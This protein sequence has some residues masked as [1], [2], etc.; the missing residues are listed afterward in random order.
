MRK[1]LAAIAE[2]INGEVVGDKNIIVTGLSGIQEAKEGDITFL[3][4][5][6]YIPLLNKTEASAVITARDVKSSKKAII[7]T[8]NPSLA[9]ANL[10]TTITGKDSHPFNG[11]HASAL[12]ADDAVIGKNVSIGPYAII[13]SKSIIGDNSIIYGG[14]Y[15]GHH[16][17]IGANALI[18]PNVIIREHVTI[19]NNIII[20]GGTVI[21]SDGFGFVH[22]DGAHRK[23]PQ[24]GTVL[25]EDDVEIG[26]NTTIDRARFGQ[27]VI[28]KGTKIDNLVQIA[29]NVVLG[30]QCIIVAQVG[31]SGSVNVGKGAILAGQAGVTGHLKIGE[32]AIVNAQSGVLKSVPAH[33]HVIGFPAKPHI[34][35][36]RSYHHLWK[37]PEY[38]KTIQKLE[39]RVEE[40]EKKLKEKG[41]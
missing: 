34:Q 13:E 1:T 32:G 9:F 22:V 4:N 23:I 41:S 18:Y 40:L 6:K 36:K 20:H 39:R 16:T 29:H 8:D 10:I 3:S 38:V 2:I 21:G 19:G 35:M 25:I 11:I 12:I 30:E 15:I 5:P 7:R 24:I 26:A 27:T 33:Q 37:L 28:G 14:G 31:I 17:S